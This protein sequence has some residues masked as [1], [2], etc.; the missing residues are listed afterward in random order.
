M[1]V[2]AKDEKSTDSSKNSTFKG[3]EKK[4][5]GDSSKETKTDQKANKDQEKPSL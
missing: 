4:D 2:Q 5:D 1:D 3:T